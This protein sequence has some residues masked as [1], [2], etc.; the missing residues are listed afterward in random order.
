MDYLV[1]A[2]HELL[3]DWTFSVPHLAFDDARG[4]AKL[5]QKNGHPW[6][7][8]LLYYQPNLL[9]Q[10]GEWGVT[11]TRLLSVFDYIQDVHHVSGQKISYED[12][13][14]PR[15]AHFVLTNFHLR[16]TLDGKPYAQVVFSSRDLVLWV[17]YLDDEGKKVKRL[18]FDS[19]GFI[20]REEDYEDGKPC[21]HIYFDE[22]GH[23][24]INHNLVTGQ[25][26]TNMA[27][28]GQ[29]AHQSY[30]SLNDLVCEVVL[31]DLMPEVYRSDNRLVVS[32]DDQLPFKP[33]LLTQVPT[34]YSVSQWHPYEKVLGQ[35][36]SPQTAKFVTD[37]EF[38]A[39]KVQQQLNLP[40]PSMNVPLFYSQ[41][42]LGHSQRTA[43]QRIVIFNENI[44]AEE[45]AA[46]VERLYGRLLKNYK[47]EQLYLLS[48]SNAKSDEAKAVF[49]WLLKNHPG[50]FTI[51]KKDD[52]KR[53]RSSL[54]RKPKIPA[55]SLKVVRADNVATAMKVLD[56]TRLLID[57][58]K[59]PDEFLQMASISTGIPRLQRIETEE[60]HDHENGLIFSN[61]DELMQ[62]VSFY[63]DGLKNWNNALAN[64]VRTLNQYSSEQLFAKWQQLWKEGR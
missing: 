37:T 56:L 3:G 10:L 51:K 33:D 14:W 7:A 5:L 2:W 54:D 11:P 32:L 42:K 47:S 45:L 43:W 26:L 41:F 13:N 57:P 40:A 48:Y 18:Q 1:P 17:D 36:A 59:L 52:E 62:G 39:Q 34:I 27:F 50:E 61:L 44:S 38:T 23:W 28:A 30:Q 24:R 31:T 6:G 29:F 60:V 46:L 22:M 16:V 55:L 58:G 4:Q 35:I 20:S 21:R 64:N 15:N 63:L 53:S 25:V 49:Q 19:R 9:E 12:L 8:I